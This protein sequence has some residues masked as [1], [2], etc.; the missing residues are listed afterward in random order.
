MINNVKQILRRFYDIQKYCSLS[1]VY[2]VLYDIPKPSNSKTLK[3]HY[4]EFYAKHSTL[5]PSP[6]PSYSGDR[7]GIGKICTGIGNGEAGEPRKEG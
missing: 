4:F 1:K 5:T 7:L 2:G 6:P 3:L